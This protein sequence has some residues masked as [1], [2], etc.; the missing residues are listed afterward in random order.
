MD[1]SSKPCLRWGWYQGLGSL[2]SEGLSH[3]AKGEP[4]EVAKFIAECEVKIECTVWE[5]DDERLLQP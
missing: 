1:L 2:T 5:G 4:P 3:Q